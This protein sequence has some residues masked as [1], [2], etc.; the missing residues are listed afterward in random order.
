MGLYID[1]LKIF[2][3]SM[4]L[5]SMPVATAWKC[6]EIFDAVDKMC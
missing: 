4:Q 6:R 5:Y 3:R 1:D 2:I